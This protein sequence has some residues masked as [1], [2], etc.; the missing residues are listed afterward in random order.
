MHA[1]I[2]K[3]EPHQKHPSHLGKNQL[4][5]RFRESGKKRQNDS[6]KQLHRDSIHYEQESVDS[7]IYKGILSEF[8][9][10][11][12]KGTSEHLKRDLGQRRIF[13]NN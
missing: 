5:E 13:P 11:P 12:E 7:E 3:I 6:M 8:T 1:F 4:L 2:P 9:R 10:M